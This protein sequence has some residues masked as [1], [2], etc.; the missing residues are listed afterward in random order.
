MYAPSADWESIRQ[1]KEAVSIPVIGN[2]DVFTAEDAAA[3][4]EQTGCD[5]VM[6]GPVSYTHLSSLGF[7]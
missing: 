1:V 5:L 3:M 4:L 6:I 2:G 7:V